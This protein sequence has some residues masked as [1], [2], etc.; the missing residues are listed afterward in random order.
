MGQKIECCSSAYC[1]FPSISEIKTPFV[2]NTS[3]AKCAIRSKLRS[4]S[5][6]HILNLYAGARTEIIACQIH[7]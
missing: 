5:V 1:S 4:G 3:F 2:L 6:F 7:E